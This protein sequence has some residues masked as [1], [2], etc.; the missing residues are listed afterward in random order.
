MS[1]T[2]DSL[3][4]ANALMTLSRFRSQPRIGHLDRAKNIVGYLKSYPPATICF[5]TGIPDHEA[6]YGEHPEL[7]NW[8]YLVYD[9]PKEQIPHGLPSPKGKMVPTTMFVDANLMHD[10]ITSRAATGVLRILNQPPIDYF[11]KR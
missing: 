9:Q 10:A 1:R 5:R 7:H 11:L 3:N 6:W 4:I 8:M 2:C